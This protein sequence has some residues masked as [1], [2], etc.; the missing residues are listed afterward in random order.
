MNII[1]QLNRIRRKAW[2]LYKLLNPEREFGKILTWRGIEDLLD[3]VRVMVKALLHDRE[4]NL[5]ERRELETTI[6]GLEEESEELE[7]QRNKAELMV[8]EL[9]V[10]I[11]DL[12]RKDK[13]KRRT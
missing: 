9:E 10:R 7:V 8:E 2:Q 6:V 11:A 12:E 4:S 13:R 5:R 3:S 1:D